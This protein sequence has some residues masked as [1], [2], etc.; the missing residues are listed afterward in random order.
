MLETRRALSDSAA[1]GLYGLLLQEKQLCEIEDGPALP[2]PVGNDGG[3]GEEEQELRLCSLS[4][5]ANVNALAAGQSIDFNARMTVLYGENGAGKTGY[6]RILKRAASVRTSEP[7]LP[8]VG[9]PGSDGSPAATLDYEIGGVPGSCVW[10]GEEGVSPLT[11]IDVFDAEGVDLH[12][13]GELAYVYTPSELAVFRYAHDG[14]EAVKAKLEQARQ[15]TLPA[16]NPYLHRFSRDG[17][18]YARIETLGPTTDLP[19]LEA[20][21]D[22]SEEERA[23]L[24]PLRERVDALGSAALGASLRV[25]EAE[26]EVFGRLDAALAVAERFNRGA[27]AQALGTARRAEEAHTR[28]TWEALVGEAIPGVLGEEWRRFIEAGD[29]YLAEHK[30]ED[31]PREGETCPYC[32]QDLG[33]AATAVVRKYRAFCQSDL[34]DALGEAR[35]A[36]RDQTAEVAAVPLEPLAQD[37]K[38]MIEAAGEENARSM[39][40]LAARDFVSEFRALQETTGISGDLEAAEFEA[41][42]TAAR[43]LVDARLAALSSL[44]RDLRTQASQRKEH[45]ESER[46]KLR[47]LQDRATLS[48]LLPGIRE[49]VERAKWASR[50]K[51]ILDRFPALSRSLTTASKQAGEQLLNQ[52][53]ESAFVGECEALR[54]PT[55]TLDFPGRRGQPARRKSLTPQHRLRAILSE[56]EQ[57][58][59]ALADFIAEATLRRSPTPIVLDDPVTSLDYKRLQYVV[60]RLVELS[61]T[62]QVIVFTHNIWFTMELL[63]RFDKD[64]PACAYYDVSGRD[65][66]RGVV[67]RGESPRLDT[68]SDKKARINRLIE[69]A[70]SE[71]DSFMREVFVEKGYDDMRG[72]CEII[73]ENNL[74]QSVVGSYRPNVMVGNLL[75]VRFKDL[76]AATEI[77]NEVFERCC[78]FTGGHKQPLETLSVRPSLDQL[79][80]DWDAL[81]TVHRQ[82]ST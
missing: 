17:T 24:V 22:I 49:F 79:T 4:G 56:G 74:L 13:D 30:P 26:R 58:V 62:R 40:L 60:D 34:Q 54:A 15:E 41:T 43:P 80:E 25:A 23:Q 37:V 11:R 50:A 81:K 71:E 48:E 73:V 16:G 32:L 57:K 64:R 66:E 29:A 59:I 7:I 65:T 14:I 8:N 1:A 38:E 68:W 3:P 69:R 6:V 35:A 70:R 28:A 55:V 75:R 36:L 9:R 33:E 47:D 51:L 63:A 20:I 10:T 78:R 46:A 12:V 76:P 61:E 77:V 52:D 82:F 72:A 21:A 31:Y 53:F 27:Y 5:V 2:D 42:T 67:S 18:L 44:V 39:S 45:L 19:E